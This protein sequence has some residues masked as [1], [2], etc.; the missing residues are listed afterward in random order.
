MRKHCNELFFKKPE[1]VFQLAF[2]LLLGLVFLSEKHLR[3]DEK[4]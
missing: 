1:S 4:K 2:L 3:V